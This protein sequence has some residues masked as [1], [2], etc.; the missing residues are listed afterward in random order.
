MVFYIGGGIMIGIYLIIVIIYTGPKKLSRKS[1][2][3]MPFKA[4]N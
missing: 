4:L 2:S 1:D 3:E